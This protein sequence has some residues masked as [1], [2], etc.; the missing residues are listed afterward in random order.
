MIKVDRVRVGRNVGL[1]NWAILCHGSM[2]Q[3]C[4]SS[5]Q[6]NARIKIQNAFFFYYFHE[7]QKKSGT[8]LIEWVVVYYLRL[9]PVPHKKDQ[10]T[11]TFWRQ[12]H[13]LTSWEQQT[14]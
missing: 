7:K 8:A 4:A 6:S 3:K 9:I 5:A 10:S 2:I 13:C 11:D 14:K 12:S 1:Q